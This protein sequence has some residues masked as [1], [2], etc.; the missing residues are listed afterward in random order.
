MR[1][2]ILIVTD[3]IEPNTPIVL[4]Y[5]NGQRV[6]CLNTDRVHGVTMSMVIRGDRSLLFFEKGAA[7]NTDSISS[8]QIKSVW[9]RRP[10]DVAM[11]LPEISSEAKRFAEREAQRFLMSAWHG[12]LLGQALWV[13]HPL[14]LR[15]VESNKPLQLE[16]ASEAGLCTPTTLM[17]NNRDEAYAFYK[18][19][20]GNIIMKTLGGTK[21]RGAY[22]DVL[23]VF[24]SRVTLRDLECYGDELKYC[25]VIFQNYIPKK[26]ELRTTIVGNQVF[27][28]AIHSQDSVATRDDWRRYDL[29]GVKHEEFELPKHIEEKLF[30]CMKKWNIQFG[31]VDMILTPKGDFVFL[32]VNPSG[33][34]GWIEALT[35][36]PISESVANLLA[37]PDKHS[38]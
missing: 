25:P 21:L 30:L 26:L 37:N 20:A 2:V 38:I 13:N 33:Q 16:T 31:A 32:E 10:P 17:T 5:L 3:T 8:D 4:N 9:Y 15:K 27:T 24:T 35:G 7:D 28:C 18:A 1:D 14:A 29:E 23:G 11:D 34:W 22:G 19:H 6:L 36:M 12:N